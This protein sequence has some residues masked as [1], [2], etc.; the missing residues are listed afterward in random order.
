M[1]P[2]LKLK[3][4]RAT[5]WRRAC[6]KKQIGVALV[7]LDPLGVFMDHDFAVEHGSGGVCR[8]AF[9][10]FVR[11]SVG[12]G[13]VNPSVVV[14]K[15]VAAG[16]VASVEGAVSMLAALMNVEVIPKPVGAG[17]GRSYRQTAGLGLTKLLMRNVVR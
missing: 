8:Q 4:S 17:R 11:M 13:V 5:G 10:E 12:F 9:V 3:P 1:K 15:G 14:H 16:Q 6:V 7:G 2:S